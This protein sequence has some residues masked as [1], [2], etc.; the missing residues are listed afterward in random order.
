[1]A[2]IRRSHWSRDG[3]GAAYSNKTDSLT[4][5]PFVLIFSSEVEM[6]RS[7]NLDVLATNEDL[8]FNTIGQRSLLLYSF[9]YL[10]KKFRF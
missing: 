7:G 10:P 4:R 5:T 6:L 3:A 9:E 8:S 1:M 2:N